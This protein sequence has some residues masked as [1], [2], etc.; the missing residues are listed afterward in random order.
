MIGPFRY[1]QSVICIGKK[2]SGKTAVAKR[3]LVTM[4]NVVIVD[5]KKNESWDAVAPNARVEGDERI[6]ECGQ[7]R[8]HWVVSDEFLHDRRMQDSHFKRLYAK[9]GPRILYVDELGDMSRGGVAS[10]ALGT[11]AM[12]GRSGLHGLWGTTQRPHGVPLYLMSEADHYF[13]FKLKLSQDQK[14]A[15]ELLEQEI[16]WDKLSEEAHNFYY[17]GPAGRV[18]GPV[19]LKRK[20]LIP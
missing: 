18:I 12:R 3:A 11:Y 5:S 13:I 9:P 6:H 8:F 17:R 1:D 10:D 4:P 16:D 2:G 14:R 20:D 19:S 15:E 7:G